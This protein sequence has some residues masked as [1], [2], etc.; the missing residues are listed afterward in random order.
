MAELITVGALVGWAGPQSGLLP[1]PALCGV[2]QPLMGRVGSWMSWL[3]GLGSPG[4][5][6]GLQVG[7]VWFL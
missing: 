4:G 5:G 7:G 6:A 3:C 1:A 2:C